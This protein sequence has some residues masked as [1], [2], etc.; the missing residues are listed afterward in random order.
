MHF[1]DDNFITLR[2]LIDKAIPFLEGLFEPYAEVVYLPG[3]GFTAEIV[4]D[5]DALIIRTRTKC[6]A[7]LLRGSS[8][9]IIATATIGYDHIDME[10]CRENNIKVSTAAGCN[11]RGVLQ[12]FGACLSHLS[13]RDGWHPRD[14]RLGVVGVGNVG[15]LIAEY[16]A[17]W[18]FDVICCDPPRGVEGF[19]ELEEMLPLVDIITFHTPLD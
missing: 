18:G 15:S 13:R 10:Y 11:A 14:M 1:A 5:A 7:A 4:Q 19:V 2:I 3:D 16:G 9:S 17:M 8:V 12:W 6:N